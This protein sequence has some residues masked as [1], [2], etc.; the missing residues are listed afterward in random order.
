MMAN[1]EMVTKITTAITP[2]KQRNGE[3]DLCTHI[4]DEEQKDFFFTVKECDKIGLN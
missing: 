1:A 3:M 2:A 4:S